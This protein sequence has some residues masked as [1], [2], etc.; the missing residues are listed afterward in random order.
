MGRP[1]KQKRRGNREGSINHRADGRWTAQVMVGY[2]PVTGKPLRPTVYAHTRDEVVEKL[3]ELRRKYR[4]GVPDGEGIT[5]KDYLDF[6]LA[7]QK[8]KV[9]S[10]TYESYQLHVS[11]VV[12]HLGNC[13]LSRLSG[14]DV[15]RLY[16]KLGEEGRSTAAVHNAG[17]RLRQAL[18]KAVRLG[19]IRT[20]PVRTDTL[21]RHRP[22]E[23]PTLAPGQV[24]QFF[25]A[26]AGDRL[27]AFYVVAVSTGARLGELVALDWLSWDE[28]RGTLA[29]NKAVQER[30]GRLELKEPKSRAGRRTIPL[31]PA[32]Q[33]ALRAHRERMRAEGR[34][35]QAGVIFCDSNGGWLRQSNLHRRSYK[36]ALRRA[37][38]SPIPFHSLRH[39][40]ATLLVLEGVDVLS[41]ANRLGHSSVNLVH[42]TYGHVVPAMQSRAA[43]A[44][45][46]FLPQL[47]SN[48]SQT[49]G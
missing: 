24:R 15:T 16:Q 8:T 21:P 36:P 9:R 32:A 10:T 18:D 26:L 49:G 25:Q 22:A 38:L 42:K 7:G 41:V 34:D 19:Y 39:T 46:E 11:Y 12:P 17:S 27:E 33:A 6:W 43:A 4:D 23:R 31:G 45:D 3:D 28:A 30:G 44:I 20:N 47:P 1:K 48:S 37:G 2:D 14:V 40:A 35:V 29:V 13:I 5:L